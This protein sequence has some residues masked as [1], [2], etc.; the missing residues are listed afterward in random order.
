MNEPKTKNTLADLRNHLF[1]T[2]EALQDHDSGMDTARA[3]AICDVSGRIIDS[4]KVEV[5]MV[6]AIGASKPASP[7][8]FSFQEE[9]RELPALVV[10]RI[11][12]K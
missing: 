2:L 10:G 7:R 3:R 11:E 5:E 1:A 9:S 8:F 6:R 4:A 12:G